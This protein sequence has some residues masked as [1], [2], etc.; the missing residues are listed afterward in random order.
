MTYFKQRR[1]MEFHKKNTLEKLVE[2]GKP[3]PEGTLPSGAQGK[4]TGGV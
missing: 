1:V 4:P 2:G 3:V